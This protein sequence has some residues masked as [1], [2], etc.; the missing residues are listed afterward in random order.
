MRRRFAPALML[1]LACALSAKGEDLLDAV[2]NTSP[3]PAETNTAS[4]A[5]TGPLV[6]AAK[7]E[8]L[9][10]AVP[11]GSVT[12]TKPAQAS[13]ASAG[14]DE[15]RHIGNPTTFY[16]RGG[17]GDAI[18]VS[19]DWTRPLGNSPFDLN[20][21][22]FFLQVEK[23]YRYQSYYTTSWYSWW[24]GWHEN[25]HYYWV[26]DTE[27][28]ADYGGEA[29]CIWR[30]FRGRRLSPYAG[31]GLRAE[32]LSW[33]YGGFESDYEDDSKA[34]ASGRF[35]LQL[36]LKRIYIVGEY[37][38]GSESSELIGDISFYISGRCKLHAF[39]ENVD[40]DLGSGTAFG[41]GLSFDF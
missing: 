6:P 14:R 23:D 36:D 34:S 15:K 20:I 5:K 33:K 22:A 10:D 19:V 4:A 29:L 31:V 13:V 21:R 39:V 11:D 41:G 30:P 28:Q 40:L 8:N 37:I 38:M 16:V 27:Y 35:G 9:V 18:G 25:R 3:A 1:L 7:G 32:K 2:L 24:S 12:L 17:G 26:D